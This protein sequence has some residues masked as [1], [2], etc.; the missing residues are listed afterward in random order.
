[1]FI[2]LWYLLFTYLVSHE[3]H[4]LSPAD[5]KYS[6]NQ[7]RG[8]SVSCKSKWLLFTLSSTHRTGFSE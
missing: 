3:S 8:K 5:I 1:M 2:V 6:T 4:H 7:W